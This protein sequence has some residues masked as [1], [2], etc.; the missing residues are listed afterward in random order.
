MVSNQQVKHNQSQYLVTDLY[1]NNSSK[2]VG[3]LKVPANQIL[4]VLIRPRKR[5]ART[6]ECPIGKKSLQ[7]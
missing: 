6:A 7:E 5:E 1:R 4:A 2:H 3:V